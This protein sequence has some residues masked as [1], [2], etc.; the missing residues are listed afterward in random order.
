MLFGVFPSERV[1]MMKLSICDSSFS[2]SVS[3]YISVCGLLSP[4]FAIWSTFSLG[5]I[6]VWLGI[7]MI[8][9]FCFAFPICSMIVE[10]C[11]G[12]AFDFVVCRAKAEES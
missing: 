9:I 7:H 8:E 6:S 1:V 5:F 2:D 10:S 3:F 4:V 12:L 11:L